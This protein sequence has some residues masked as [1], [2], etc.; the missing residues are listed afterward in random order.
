MIHHE[1]TAGVLNPLE[2]VCAVL[3]AF[4]GAELPLIVD[5]MSAFGAYEVDLS[6]KHSAVKYLISSANKNMEGVGY[7][8]TQYAC[9][10]FSFVAN[11]YFAMLCCHVRMG[12]SCM[13][14]HGMA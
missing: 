5:S 7:R 4:P 8:R 1:T 6:G 10:F 14:W 2:E 3:D 9:E 12:A 11:I 13:V